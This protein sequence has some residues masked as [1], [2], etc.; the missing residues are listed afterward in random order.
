MNSEMARQKGEMV[1]LNAEY[2]RIQTE[3]DKL[4]KGDRPLD[5]VPPPVQTEV[6]KLNAEVKTLKDRIQMLEDAIVDK[7][8]D[9][10]KLETKVQKQAADRHRSLSIPGDSS[11]SM[12]TP[13]S[14]E[15]FDLLQRL[16]KLA[17]PDFGG[18][19]TDKDKETF[20]HDCCDWFNRVIPNDKKRE[21]ILAI[22]KDADI[23][24]NLDLILHYCMNQYLM[25]TP[26]RARRSAPYRTEEDAV[27]E[28]VPTKPPFDTTLPSLDRSEHRRG[29]LEKDS[30]RNKDTR[31][32][33]VQLLTDL[34]T[35]HACM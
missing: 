20:I 6:V 34:K 17:G 33:I 25:G 15:L 9:L 21:F 4:S 24:A 5:P 11:R 27:V 30:P 18:V 3:M 7:N 23:N 8:N 1:A 10:Y 16:Q 26:P 2:Q 12:H 29:I 28:E 14:A 35:M 22:N 19:M 31:M 13:D 32:P